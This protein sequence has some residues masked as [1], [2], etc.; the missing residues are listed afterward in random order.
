MN[1]KDFG[2]E[3][4]KILALD[5]IYTAN[6]DLSKD[7][8]LGDFSLLK[9]RVNNLLSYGPTVTE[10]DFDKDGV[11][12]INAANKVGKCVDENTEIEI[13]FDEQ[14]IIDKLG[15]LPTELK[16]FLLY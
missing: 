2:E 11:I 5:E 7:Y 8:E 12:G 14:Y 9:I 15:F 10:F 3:I 4:P 16:D 1:I 13:E 6:L